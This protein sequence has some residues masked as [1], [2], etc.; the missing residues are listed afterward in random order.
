MSK[1]RGKQVLFIAP[2]FFG[3]E[4]EIAGE[5]R[6][7]GASVDFLPDRPFASPLM[8][9]V[10]RLRSEWVLPFADR[11]FINSVEAFG[12]T[13][14][15]L[16]FVVVGEAVSARVLMELRKSFPEAYFVLY[17]WDAIRTKQA[18][19]VNLSFFDSTHTFDPVD[20]R[21]FD[22]K[23]RPLFFSPGFA[24]L[25]VA[26]A[27]PQ[28]QLSFVGTVHSDRYKIVS[29]VAAA[30]PV[31]TN[32]YRYLY[33]QAPWV[34]WAHKL[35]NPAY[36]NASVSSFCFDPLAKS[37]VQDIFFKSRA[38]LDIEHPGQT[39]LTMRTFETIGTGKK[40]ITTNA[41]VKNSDFFNPEN[42]LVID[43][44]RVEDIPESFLGTAYVPL[45]DSL[46]QKY[47]LEGWLADI[48]PCAALFDTGGAQ[49]SPAT[50]AKDG[51][52]EVSPVPHGHQ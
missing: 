19:Q 40:L 24:R 7:Q 38:V 42:I 1:L 46:Y 43:R 6:R 26:E 34:F 21:T 49:I 30:L 8:K 48:V 4:K 25:N 32:F 44:N 23:F 45:E 10:T 31:H 41:L 22:M 36:R 50:R 33:L 27:E 5:M 39:G 15:D 20:A 9:A 47:S 11:F 35:G 16:I 18:A 13:R 3:Y 17:M 52:F 28:Y 14:Y 29:N 12:R 51:A 2:Q 37:E